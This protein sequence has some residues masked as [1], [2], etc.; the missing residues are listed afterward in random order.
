MPE[1]ITMPKMSD[2]MTT[3]TIASWLVKVGDTI[4]TGDVIAEV[5]T[6]KATMDLESYEDGTVLYLAGGKGDEIAVD[7]V[8]AIIG[9]K[10]ASYQHLLNQ[11]PAIPTE[12]PKSEPA[13]TQEATEKN[14]PP[15]KKAATPVIDSNSDKRLKVSP[16]ARKLAEEKGYDLTKIKGSA[17]NGRI[18]KRDIENHQPVEV[19]APAQVTVGTES[20]RDEEISPMRKVIAQRLSESKFQAPHFYVTTEVNMDQTIAARESMN[21]FSKVKISFNDLIVKTAAKALK[22]HSNVNASWL[23]DSI[24]YYNHVHIG[25]AVAVEEGLLVPVVRFADTKPLSE[26]AEETKT[27]V[28]K[29]KEKKL[30]P[31]EWEGNTFTVSNLGMFDV[32]SFT[33]II[34]PP[35][36]A[37]LAVGQ[38]QKKPVVKNDTLVIG[39]VMKLTLSC[40]HRVIDGVTGAQFLKTV[41]N[42][43]EDPVRI[44]V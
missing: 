17:S 27:L 37:I 16:L 38:I 40:D 15:A 18:I 21:E 36:S 23:G 3:G 41:K 31:H 12:T 1:V 10:N 35:D 20:Y 25:V 26:I 14:T 28:T 24:R 19:Q 11:T 8:V 13:N 4:E 22:A 29:A 30:Q 33:A 7:D 39:N 32:E 43:L 5:E 2:T 34:N 44:L 42:L 6:D 9:E